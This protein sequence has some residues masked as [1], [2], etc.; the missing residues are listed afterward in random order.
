M[1]NIAVIGKG[2]REHALSKFL[3][4]SNKY[5]EVFCIPGNDGMRL[6]DIHCL[7]WDSQNYL[8]LVNILKSNSILKVIIGPEDLL[9][10]GLS[11]YLESFKISVIGPSKKLSLLESSKSYSKNFMFETGIPCASS[12]S[13]SNSTKAISYLE[14]K[15]VAKT[16]IVIKSSQL[17]SGKGVVVTHDFFEARKTILDFL[18][19]NDCSI[20]TDEILI[21][22]YLEGVESSVFVL[23]SGKTYKILGAARDYKRLNDDNVGPNTGGMGALFK[24]D[25]LSESQ[26]NEVSSILDKIC[27]KFEKENLDYYGFLFLGL[28]HT[29]DG[30]KVLE[31]NCRMGDPETQIVIPNCSFDLVEDFEKTFRK[32]TLS[33]DQVRHNNSFGIHVVLSSIGYPDIYN[34]GMSRGERIN[35]NVSDIDSKIYYAGVKKNEKGYYVNSSGR[36]L[37]LSYLGNDVGTCIEKVYGDINKLNTNNFHFRRDIGK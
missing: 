15:D 6:S 30:T 9:A 28:M 31:F 25:L 36:I 19:S 32:E 21:E 33:N 11:D 3:L 10:N 2:G 27:V 5:T 4:D 18:D 22:D 1:S 34:K 16:G 29:N 20:N 23:F 37:G 17:A 7:D 14:S 24:E 12:K 35:T 8:E 13:F 26:W